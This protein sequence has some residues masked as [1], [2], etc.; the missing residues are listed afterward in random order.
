[1]EPTQVKSVLDHKEEALIIDVRTP[2]EYVGKLGHIPGAVLRPV[3]QIDDWAGEFD[4]Y[5]D[6]KVIM[7]CRSGARSSVAADHFAKKGFASVY[8]MTGGMKA[9]NQ[10][11]FPTEKDLPERLQPEGTLRVETL[12]E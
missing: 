2:E 12:E 4:S 10:L 3:Q 5:R 6:K 11:S 8:T 7:V 9:W 1:M